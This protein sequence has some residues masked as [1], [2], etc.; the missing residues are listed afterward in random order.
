MKLDISVVRYTAMFREL[1]D[2]ILLVVPP[3]FLLCQHAKVKQ[4]FELLVE[5]YRSSLSLGIFPFGQWF[6]T[7]LLCSLVY[8]IVYGVNVAFNL[9]LPGAGI[10]AKYVQILLWSVLSQL[11]KSIVLLIIYG[12]AQYLLRMVDQL[13]D[14][15]AAGRLSTNPVYQEQIRRQHHGPAGYLMFYEQLGKVCETLNDLIGVPLITYFLMALIHL[16]FVCYLILTKLLVRWSYITWQ[17]LLIAG[18]AIASYVIDLLC[19]MRIVGTFARTREE[20]RRSLLVYCF[21]IAIIGPMGRCWVYLTT[22][23]TMNFGV[24]VAHYTAMFMEL[25]DA[26]LLA[27]P[28]C[29]LLCRHKKVKELFVLLVKVYYS[30]LSLSI[31]PLRLWFRGC[32]LFN[33]V[34]DSAYGVNVVLNVVLPGTG[35]HE[36]YVKILS[37]SVLSQLTKSIVL[38]IIYGSA[39]YLLRMVDQLKDHLVDGRLST[40]PVFQEQ[41]RQQHH[42]PAGYLEFY[43]QLGKV[44]ETLNDLY[45]VP[46]ITYFLMTLIHLTFVC[47]MTLTKVLTRWS[48]IS[49][50]AL[51]IAGIAVVSNVIDLL[52]LMK[53]VGTFARTREECCVFNLGYEAAHT[54]TLLANLALQSVFPEGMGKMYPQTLLWIAL[55]NLTKSAVL[56]TMYGGVQYLMLCTVKLNELLPRLSSWT[57]PYRQETLRRL[58]FG[59][60]GLMD[61]YGQLWRGAEL[62]NELFGPPLLAYLAIA[63]IHTT[64]IYYRVWSQLAGGLEDQPLVITVHLIV[65]LVWV[66]MDLMFLMAVVGSCGQ[67][68][69]EVSI[70]ACSGGRVSD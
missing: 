64:T 33:L 59:R 60:D 30:S 44:C 55:S 2:A 4:L 35:I 42:G 11:T 67:M 13:K 49:W 16:T 37:W 36:K 54:V 68:R 43:E 24:S 10:N 50:H 57:D 27:V 1:L 51:L 48:F 39:Q 22:F 21:I 17:A 32:F 70:I 23:F 63:F 14:H 7:C 12:S 20:F 5:I 31:F 52:C 65:Q 58:H 66:T 56:L 53:I 46:L 18:I 28:P 6:R 38:L 61:F 34:Y 19:L 40:N 3:C 9:V 26:I 45:G 15:L 69:Q 41:I 25:L 47:Y 29:Y 8:D 62:A